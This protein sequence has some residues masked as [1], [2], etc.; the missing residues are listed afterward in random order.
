MCIQYGGMTTTKILWP[1]DEQTR[2]SEVGHMTHTKNNTLMGTQIPWASLLP[3]NLTN[4]PSS[5]SR[6]KYCCTEGEVNASNRLL[7][8]Y[9]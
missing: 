4:A 3:T 8:L 6:P 7:V 5:S 1:A 2:V 9:L